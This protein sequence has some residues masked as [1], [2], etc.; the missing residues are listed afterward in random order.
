MQFLA[1]DGQPFAGQ[2]SEGQGGPDDVVGILFGRDVSLLFE[3]FQPLVDGDVESLGHALDFGV[4]VGAG[5]GNS[6]PPALFHDQQSVDHAFEHL[7]A[8]VAETIAG[9]VVAGDALGVHGGHNCR[10][11]SPRE[12]FI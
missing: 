11:G 9:E 10:D 4:H 2:S 6:L 5:H 8:A 1:A 12:L 7:F 3:E